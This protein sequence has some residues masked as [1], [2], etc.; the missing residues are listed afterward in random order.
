MLWP[1]PLRDHYRRNSTARAEIPFDLRPD[2]SGPP[3]HVFEHLVD[4]VL[5]K[6]AEVAVR[7]QIFFERFEFQAGFVRHIAEGDHAEVRQAGFRTY[8]SEF[9]VIDYDLVSGKLVGPGFDF[10]K[11][12]V[13]SG[14]GVLRR[15]AWLL[16]H[17]FIVISDARALKRVVNSNCLRGAEAPLFHDGSWCRGTVEHCANF[18]S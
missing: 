11:F 8:R 17:N 12:G 3:D 18:R 13:Q 5:L 4:D 9:R 2:R 16:G 15:V 6:N 1:R 10:R 7:L 14:F